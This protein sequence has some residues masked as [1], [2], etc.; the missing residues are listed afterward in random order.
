[1]KR[2]LRIFV[3]AT[4]ATI[5]TG[6]SGKKELP[7]QSYPGF[8]DETGIKLVVLLPG[9]GGEGDLYEEQGFI[10]GIRERGSGNDIIA[11]DVKPD[12]YLRKELVER[13]KTHVIT[14]AKHKGYQAIFLVGT[15]LGG[16]GALLYVTEHPEDIDGV[17][18]FAPFITGYPPTDLVEQPEGLDTWDEEECPF[19]EWTYACNVWKAIKKYGSNPEN[20]E[21][22]YLLYGT[23][24]GFAEELGIL[25]EFLLPENVF[26]TAGGHNWATWKKLWLELFDEA[27]IRRRKGSKW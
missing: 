13:L 11:V 16:H 7:I 25:A 12:I 2:I 9:I 4:M 3:I 15:S 21:K 22:I 26:T 18:L 17:F 14:P 10:E 6:C 19:T 5:L 1:M 27:K 23:E 8:G 20:L 24:D